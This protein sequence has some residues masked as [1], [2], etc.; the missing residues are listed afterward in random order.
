MYVWV[1]VDYLLHTAE[2]PQL[3]LVLSLTTSEGTCMCTYL[4]RFLF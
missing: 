3:D 4:A 2:A 1:S